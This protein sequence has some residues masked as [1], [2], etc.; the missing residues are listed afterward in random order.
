MRPPG[1]I[2][3]ALNPAGALLLAAICACGGDPREASEAAPAAESFV[4]PAEFEPHR[5]LW[6]AWPT[7]ENKQ[8]LST[9]PLLIDIIRATEGRVAIEL[10]A[11]DDAEAD[12]IRERF[13]QEE[14]P[15]GHVA[16]HT[17]PHGDI[18]MRDMGPIFLRGDRGGL[19]VVD[20]GFNMWGY[21]SPDSPNSRLEE[22]VDRHVADLLGLEVVKSAL[23]SEGGSREFNGKGVMLAVE[24][25]EL[26]RN[27]GWT[28]EAMEE[29]FRRT[30]GIS[31]VIWLAE[32][33][34]EDELTFRGRLPGGVYTVITTGGHVDEFARFADPETILLAEVTEEERRTDPI[35]AISHERLEESFRRLSAATDQDGN[36]FRIVRVPAPDS[37]FE[38]M[39]AGDGVFDYI[40]PLE[41][42]DGSTIAPDDAIKV[43]AAASYLNFQVTNGL[44]L[45]QKY[46]KPGMPESLREKDERALA[47]LR[48]VFPGREVLP[49]DAMA[50]NLG[51][52]GIHCI[53]QQEPRRAVR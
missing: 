38:T 32:G 23:I 27:P 11:Q 48:E 14:V 26:Q 34:A 18:W 36:P 40:Q 31:K 6:M 42:E 7:Y 25:V 1:G 4:F 28:F 9:E 16:I 13:R 3:S 49:L 24:A 41:Y 8:G 5:A 33:M 46:W 37:L 10:L 30:L 50:V 43:V 15:D 29:E 22:A 17:V 47:I 12:R 44:V 39:R 52:G 19:R 51:G 2:S 21:E 53:L 20:F 45:A 35:A